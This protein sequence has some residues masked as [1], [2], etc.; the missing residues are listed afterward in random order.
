MVCSSFTVI[1][2]VRSTG[3]RTMRKGPLSAVTM[4]VVPAAV[5]AFV[6]ASP[7]HII[8]IANGSEVNGREGQGSGVNGREGQGSSNRGTDLKGRV[9]E[10]ADLGALTLRTIRLPDGRVLDLARER[11]LVAR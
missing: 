7:A 5:A 8:R 3:V 1:Q 2:A 9:D 4:L 11:P 10:A 6:A